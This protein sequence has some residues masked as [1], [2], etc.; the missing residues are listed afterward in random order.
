METLTVHFEPSMS[1]QSELLQA[2]SRVI[3]A[4]KKQGVVSRAEVKTV[5]PDDDIKYRGTFTVSFV[6]QAGPVQAAVNQLSGVGI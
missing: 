6:G 4:L 3:D 1:S 2:L 5:F